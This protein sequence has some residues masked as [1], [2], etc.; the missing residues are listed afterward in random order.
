MN[1]YNTTKIE[2]IINNLNEPDDVNLFD[3]S[4]FVKIFKLVLET[5]DSQ[6]I[7]SI[8]RILNVLSAMENHY[9]TVETIQA[10]R[11]KG[12]YTIS[13]YIDYLIDIN[14]IKIDLKNIEKDIMLHIRENNINLPPLPR[15]TED[16]VFQEDKPSTIS[17][18][19]KNT[20]LSLASIVNVNLFDF[21]KKLKTIFA[22]LYTCKKYICQ[23]IDITSNTAIFNFLKNLLGPSMRALGNY[24]VNALVNFVFILCNTEDMLYYVMDK[25]S[26][27]GGKKLGLY[28][29][30][31]EIG[32]QI[33][34]EA[35]KSEKINKSI[36]SLIPLKDIG[37][38]Y[39]SPAPKSTPIP[40]FN[41]HSDTSKKQTALQESESTNYVIG[42][43]NEMLDYD[44]LP[45]I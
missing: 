21:S 40:W 5:N 14:V 32:K 34:L 16:L 45:N 42:V 23:Y 26:K 18:S 27:E 43:M 10:E 6:L 3:L 35:S 33:A 24:S 39:Q 36:Q 31:T 37:I 12:K 41:K 15:T 29:S 20:L 30:N 2:N 7:L 25:Y 8:I 44:A 28:V 19:V 17:D 13:T 38:K 22:Y 1:C 11:I 4:R 9:N